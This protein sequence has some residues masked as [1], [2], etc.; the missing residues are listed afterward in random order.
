[1]RTKSL[2]FTI[3][4]L[5]FLVSLLPSSAFVYLGTNALIETRKSVLVKTLSEAQIED[6][7]AFH[8]FFGPSL[9]GFWTEQHY[10]NEAVTVDCL[11][12]LKTLNALGSVNVNRAIEYIACKQYQRDTGAGG[13]GAYFEGDGTFQG[14]N[15]YT[16]YEVVRC[17]KAFN[18]LDMINQTLLM[19][20]IT[21]RYNGTIGSF[22]ELITVVD[23]KEYAHGGFPLPFRSFKS[24]I[25]YAMPNIITTYAGVCALKELERLDLINT[26]KTYEWIMHCQAAN[27]MFKPYPDASYMPLPDWSPLKTN[28][29]EVDRYGTAIPYTFAAISALNAL[30]RLG[31]ISA[32]DK[33]RIKD[34]IANCQTRGGPVYVHQDYDRWSTSHT[35][36]AVMI[37]HDLDILNESQIIVNKINEY[38]QETQMLVLDETSLIPTPGSE[39]YGLHC[40]DAT[41]PGDSNYAIAVFNATGNMHLLDQPTPRVQK[42]WLNLIVLSAIITILTGATAI[43]VLKIQKWRSKPEASETPETQTPPSVVT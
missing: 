4:V 20:F 1:M 21:K 15:L 42:T 8:N 7:G 24:H 41:P 39:E 29:F 2:I 25:A 17:L 34:Y 9:G 10:V 40:S 30:G 14:C 5:S 38:F 33:Q 36:E 43:G 13:F 16:T 12:I 37:L 3:V 26:T 11:L 22:Q 18:S 23:G 31:N 32:E 19:D 28:P 6:L 35:Y 27:G